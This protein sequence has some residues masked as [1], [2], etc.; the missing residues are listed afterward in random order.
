M[1]VDTI[2][3]EEVV[4]M[5]SPAPSSTQS[6][7]SSSGGMS[8]GG[9][10]SS[11][12]GW[13]EWLNANP[14]Y[15]STSTIEFKSPP[16]DGLNTNPKDCF[17]VS[18]D[19]AVAEQQLLDLM[20][21]TREGGYDKRNCAL[22]WACAMIGF[23]IR[24]NQWDAEGLSND[25][26]VITINSTL[27]NLTQVQD[28]NGETLSDMVVQN[29]AG[30]VLYGAYDHAYKQNGGNCQASLA[31]ANQTL[32]NALNV[33][34]DVYQQAAAEGRISNPML[35]SLD[36]SVQSLLDPTTF[37]TWESQYIDPTTGGLMY[38]TLSFSEQCVYLSQDVSAWCADPS[39]KAEYNLGSVEGQ[40]RSAW[41]GNMMEAGYSTIYMICLI[42]MAV[43]DQYM[44]DAGSVQAELDFYT[45][46]ESSYATMMTDASNQTP[47]VDQ[48]ND[49][50]NNAEQVQMAYELDPRM[51]NSAAAADAADQILQFNDP[52]SSVVQQY[53]NPPQYDS[54][55][56]TSPGYSAW[57]NY[58][59]VPPV[60]DTGALQADQ[61]TRVQ[62][63]NTTLS[64]GQ[65]SLTNYSNNLPTEM[66]QYMQMVQEA[67][68]TMQS[69]T[70]KT[71]DTIDYSI[72]RTGN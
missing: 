54:T 18:S 36:A 68:N 32:M 10:F 72:S 45:G 64:T 11:A 47:T 70:E 20:E 51:S 52:N 30:M 33:V 49:M 29:L 53:Q 23:N 3:Y 7:S 12:Q 31:A 4:Q 16:P 15:D 40:S 42:L 66:Q 57:M 24:L 34:N 62:S 22:I 69:C 6:T 55:G 44:I 58:M 61:A 5:Q 37:N 59:Y 71:A 65:T 13:Y 9:S 21:W 63:M 38:G 1:T 25:P 17:G 46:V 2:T 27:Q 35:T 14:I 50:M 43:M 28:A 67:G 19:P 39:S 48:Y 26:S 60:D 8:V 41:M 56:A